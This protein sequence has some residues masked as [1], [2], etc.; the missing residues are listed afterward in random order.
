M[1]KKMFYHVF[2]SFFIALLFLSFFIVLPTPA[3]AADSKQI[4]LKYASYA[5]PQHLGTIIAQQTFP[6]VEKLTDGRVKVDVY[7]S[8]TL[9]PAR[10]TANGLDKGV[11][12]LAFYPLNYMAGQLPW[13]NATLIPGLIKDFGGAHDA[14]QNGLKDLVQKDIHALGLKVQIVGIP[15]SPGM[16][17]LM[18][19]GKRV[20]VPSDLKGMKIAC[21]AKGDMEVVKMLG[22]TPVA[23]PSTE[24]YEAMT[25]GV[26]NGV[27]SN[28]A[29]IW[30]RK[31]Y[32]P[33]DYIT[34]VPLGTAMVAVLA[35]ESGLAKLSPVDRSI[36]LYVA[37]R[38]LLEEAFMTATVE[39]G[40]LTKMKPKLKEVVYP[41]K[42]Q[43]KKWDEAL[44]PIQDSYL[45]A[46]KE[47]GKQVIDI[48]KKYND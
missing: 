26:V 42:E 6:M 45:K 46:N 41:T 13:F 11:A 5:P 9:F 3:S 43:L 15:F 21:P 36:V 18:T 17:I 38:R 34:M 7:H 23:M 19:K 40:Y 37:E 4:V 14:F 39:Q 27:I 1:N 20:A 12:D 44:A 2:G 35:S 30:G 29:G 47:K 31:M 10:E 16:T 24:S 25:R 28:V 32:E 48:I 22:G 33:G 8:E